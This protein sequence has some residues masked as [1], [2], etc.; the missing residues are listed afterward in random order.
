M[1]TDQEQF[2]QDHIPPATRAMAS[3]VFD[4]RIRRLMDGTDDDTTDMVKFLC[5]LAYVYGATQM[6]LMIGDSEP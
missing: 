2:L 6:E 3:T 5:I 1:R 4:K